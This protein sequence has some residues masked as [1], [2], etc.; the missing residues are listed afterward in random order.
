[1]DHSKIRLL[2]VDDDTSVC[3]SLAGFLEDFDFQT[4]LAFS[5]EEALGMLAEKPYDV[6][7]VDLRLPDMTGEAL[8]LKAYEIKPDM[9]FMV[10]T[11]SAEY[12]LSEELRKIGMKPE[13]V[14]LKPVT[15][16]NTLIVAI[17]KLCEGKD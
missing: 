14:F 12:S 13:Y 16:M 8:I 11:G 2:L 6:L 17:E 5:A 4:A 3:Q 10:N 7:I 9:H 15:D 1:M